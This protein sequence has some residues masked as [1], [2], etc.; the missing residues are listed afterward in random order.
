MAEDAA[1]EIHVKIVIYTQNLSGRAGIESVVR[2]HLRI[3][4]ARGCETLV[5]G[6]A[7]CENNIPA[8]GEAR[9]LAL[10][11]I[12]AGFRPDVCI[13]HGVSH[14]GISDDLTVL[15]KFNIPSVAVCHFSFP[16]A[17]LLDGDED[18]NRTFFA[19]AK[20]CSCVA[21]VSAIDSHWWRALGCRAFHVQN[22][23]VRPNAH[24]EPFKG[25]N[26][27]LIR[28]LWAGRQAE[29]K[30]P[31]LAIRAFAKAYMGC[32]ELRL[33]MIGGDAKGWLPY[34]KF[35]EELGCSAALTLLP[36]R[37][38]ISDLWA[39]ADIHLLSSVTESF[40]LVLAEAKNAGIPSVMF[41]I[42]FLELVQD[43]KGLISVPQGDIDAM[44]DALVDLAKNPEK[45]K[46]LGEEAKET[47]KDFTDETVWQ[48]WIRVFEALKS[49][50]GGY[51]V[52]PDVRHIVKQEF[53]AWN[54]FC[55]KNLWA[56][57]MNRNWK[58]LTHCTMCPFAKL[59]AGTVKGI[60]AIKRKLRG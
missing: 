60:R 36:A 21:T 23:F 46:K 9:R 31:D 43:G 13:L 30:Q 5:F 7:G 50:E 26:D 33:T 54:R 12:L 44:A 22:P 19:G 53:F 1:Q 45:R 18:A 8:K 56:V 49:G 28:I 17:V 40:C 42:P 35:A 20:G 25:E 55:E 59:L 38:D 37:P 15:G 14:A 32:H 11:K 29:Q 58:L 34:R 10:D 51:E 27:G 6:E 16:S 3:F 4:A 39:Q 47:L 2:E 48:S 41:D 52:S 57:E 24:N